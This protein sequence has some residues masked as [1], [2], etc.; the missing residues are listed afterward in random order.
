MDK[1]NE[2][3]N[4]EIRLSGLGDAMSRVLSEAADEEE[5]TSFSV[6]RQEF[7]GQVRVA[8]L[9]LSSRLHKF[10]D[11]NRDIFAKEEK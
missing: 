8:I 3:T 7:F 9:D 10:V 5:T 11:D 6:A 1:A 2:L 4:I